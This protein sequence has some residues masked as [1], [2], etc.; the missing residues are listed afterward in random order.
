MIVQPKIIPCKEASLQNYALYKFENV[1]DLV[2]YAK[3]ITNNFADEKC[4]KFYSK[5]KSWKGVDS[6]EQLKKRL[7]FGRQEGTDKL[8]KLVKINEQVFEQGKKLGYKSERSCQGF[9][10][11][12]AR[13]II[14]LPNSMYRLKYTK[15]PNKIINFLVDTCAS[16][17]VSSI[18]Y[19]K[20]F[21]KLFNYIYSLEKKGYRCKVT[22][23]TTFIDRFASQKHGQVYQYVV[24]HE[25]EQFNLAKMGFALTSTAFFRAFMLLLLFY[26]CELEDCQVAD[27]G[28]P[29]Y[30]EQY[31]NPDYFAEV[32]NLARQP[33]EK[34]VYVNY[35]TQIDELEKAIG[36]IN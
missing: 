2:D 12:V 30:H 11:S 18:D 20:Q 15:T 16:R 14:G 4:Y 24:K 17:N 25:Y 1:N 22:A 35:R 34:I 6:L 19:E 5:T 36:K 26:N 3:E 13:S 9:R 27:A 8:N 21:T 32:I 28:I 33:K 10:P 23:L 31:R 29:L 7:E